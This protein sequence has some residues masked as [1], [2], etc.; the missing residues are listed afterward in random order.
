MD[1][2]VCLEKSINQCAKEKMQKCV[3]LLYVCMRMIAN[4]FF[5]KKYENE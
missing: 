4:I 5:Y 2:N 1:S 3:L